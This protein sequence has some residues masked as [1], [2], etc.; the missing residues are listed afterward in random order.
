MGFRVLDPT[1]FPRTRTLNAPGRPQKG[2]PC[3]RR[4]AQN[5]NL[6]HFEFRN[7]D[8]GRGR[9]TGEVSVLKERRERVETLESR[10]V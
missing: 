7:R 5:Q 10:E 6:G 2:H 9:V 4:F 3:P 8:S 1:K